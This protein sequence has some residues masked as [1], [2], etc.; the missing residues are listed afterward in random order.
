MNW[1]LLAASIAHSGGDVLELRPSSEGHV[2]EVYYKNSVVQNSM[3]GVFVLEMGE[4]RVQVQVVVSV[5]D[6]TLI[7]VPMDPELIA[8]PDRID[9]SDGEETVVQIMRPMF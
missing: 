1:L 5:A 4:L 6:E 7:V 2:A 3:G 9:V 8:V